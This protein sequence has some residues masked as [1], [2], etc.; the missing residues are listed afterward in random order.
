M[1]TFRGPANKDPEDTST[2]PGRRWIWKLEE[3]ET[4]AA[5]KRTEGETRKR[6]PWKIE[7]K[8]INIYPDYMN[9]V[10]KQRAAFAAVKKDL[11]HNKIKYALLYLAKLQIEHERKTHFL[12]TPPEAWEWVVMRVLRHG[13]GLGIGGAKAWTAG[14]KKRK[15]AGAQT[16]PAAVPS[17]EQIKAAQMKAVRDLRGTTEIQLS[18]RWRELAVDTKRTETEQSGSGTGSEM[19]QPPQVTP[20]TAD[21]LG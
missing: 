14:K 8:E 9:M 4:I 12:G 18:D 5:L 3:A 17:Q 10:Q 6:G 1:K 11:C 2:A 13:N 19:D 15:G 7:G 16:G 21:L 20:M